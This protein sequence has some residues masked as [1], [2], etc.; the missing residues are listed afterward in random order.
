MYFLSSLN[1]F[2]C[3]IFPVSIVNSQFIKQIYGLLVLILC[4]AQSFVGYLAD[5]FWDPNRLGIVDLLS[6]FY[7]LIFVSS[8][9]P[10]FPDVVHWYLGRFT[11]ALSFIT[12]ILGNFLHFL[13][14]FVL[15][16]IHCVSFNETYILLSNSRLR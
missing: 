16:L 2:H 13:C 6:I 4:F 5:L 11:I 9:V 10:V 8:S 1:R 15:H 3:E 7:S 14:S 12:I